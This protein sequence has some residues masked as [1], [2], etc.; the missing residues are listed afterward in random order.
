MPS[1]AWQAAAGKHHASLVAKGR[2]GQ[3][4][5][6]LC[7]WSSHAPSAGRHR[8]ACRPFRDWFRLEARARHGAIDRVG[9]GRQRA[10]CRRRP[11]QD[12]VH[13]LVDG[14][15]HLLV[16]GVCAD[17]GMSLVRHGDQDQVD[18]Q[19]SCRGPH[20]LDGGD[21]RDPRRGIVCAA[22]PVIHVMNMRSAATFLLCGLMH[23]FQPPMFEVPK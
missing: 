20:R 5:S 13:V 10:G 18:L 22:G 21:L 4:R 8:P 12:G 14:Q 19:D 1:Q 7:L 2:A 9:R 15:A 6:S 23:R 16:R 11:D 3:R 17:R